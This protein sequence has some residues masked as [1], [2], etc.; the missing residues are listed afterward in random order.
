MAKAE[1]DTHSKSWKQFTQQVM[2]SVW[3]RM[4]AVLDA[5]FVRNSVQRMGITNIA[6]LQLCFLGSVLFWGVLQLQTSF[7]PFNTALPLLTACLIGSVLL[8][9]DYL[10]RFDLTDPE[11]S[12]AQL[13]DHIQQRMLAGLA[14]INNSHSLQRLAHPPEPSTSIPSNIDHFSSY[15]ARH[16][17]TSLTSSLEIDQQSVASSNFTTALEEVKHAF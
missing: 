17:I 11:A 3:E 4:H 15:P 1:A 16:T 2:N 8:Y 14:T 7:E 12:I 6:W 10:D 9:L 5:R 13:E